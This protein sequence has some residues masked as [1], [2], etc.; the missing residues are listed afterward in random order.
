MIITIQNTDRIIEINGV[1]GRI[2]EGKT[3][4]GIEVHCLITRIAIAK[5]EPPETVAQFDAELK[6]VHPPSPAVEVY[7]LKMIL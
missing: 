3:D 6:E 7:P 4:S 5:D 2:W 1:P